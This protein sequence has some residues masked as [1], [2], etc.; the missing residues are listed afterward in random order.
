MSCWCQDGPFWSQWGEGA[1][2]TAG[3]SFTSFLFSGA[4]LKAAFICTQVVQFP[5]Q[6]PLQVQLMESFGGGFEVHTWSKL[7]HGSGL[8]RSAGKGLG[9]PL[10]MPGSLSCCQHQDG[11]SPLLH[12]SP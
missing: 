12:P 9:S 6:R 2:S 5:S 4:L 7:P 8:G 11:A 1:G 3:I 10:L